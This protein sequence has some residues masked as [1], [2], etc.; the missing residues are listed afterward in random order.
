MRTTFLIENI[1]ETEKSQTAQK[2][3]EILKFW[4]EKEVFKKTLN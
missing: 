3:E 2:E 1:M 4:Q